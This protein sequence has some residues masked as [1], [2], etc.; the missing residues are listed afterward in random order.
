MIDGTTKLIAHIGYPTE[1]FKSPMIY[2]PY[3][4]KHGINAVVVPMGCKADDYDAF[5]KL[6]FRLSNMHGALITMPHKVTTLGLV[7]EASVSARIAGACNAVRIDQRGRLIGDMF[8]GEG[9][10]RGLL[11]KGRKLAGATALV[12]GCG[13]VGS[14][15]AA[16]LAKAGVAGLG[17]YDAF[18][19][20]MSELSDRLQAHY[21]HLSSWNGNSC[22]QCSRRRDLRNRQNIFQRTAA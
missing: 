10:V 20:A 15:I 14:A 8:D 21:P 1:S 13:G 17:L 22:N 11:K 7:D 4:E 3:F 2:N 6:V 12:C 5:L 9:F 16:S 18:P 19:R